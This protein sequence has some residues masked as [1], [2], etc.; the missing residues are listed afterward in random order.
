MV[1]MVVAAWIFFEG[2]VLLIHHKKTGRWMPVGGHVEADEDLLS[3][4]HREVAE[5]VGLEIEVVSAP[6]IVPDTSFS[7]ELPLP[8]RIAEYVKESHMELV[9][10]FIAKTDDADVVL[11]ESE[12][13]DA[14]WLSLED[15]QGSDEYTDRVKL[16]A[17]KAFAYFRDYQ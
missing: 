14:R 9:F 5:E 4:L 15:I 7:H 1:S 11:Q 2:K 3:A 12:I 10:D 17:A 6:T 16:L 13:L 8:F